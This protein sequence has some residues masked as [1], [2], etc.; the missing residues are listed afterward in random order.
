METESS[1]T[2]QLLRLAA[3]GDK[4]SWGKLLTL[5]VERLSRL[6]ALR[7]DRRIQGRVDAGDVIQEIYL[8]AW[9][10]LPDYVQHPSMPFYLWLRGLARNKLGELHR[11]HLGAQ[12]RD[13]RREDPQAPGEDKMPDT[14]STALNSLFL[15][16]ST[17]SKVA[18]RAEVKRQ[19]QEALES[20]DALDREVLA[21]RHFEQLTPAETAEVLGIKEKAAGMRY[22]RAIRRLKDV[23]TLLPGGLSEFRT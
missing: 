15:D 12:M 18:A 1:E 17:P 19:L 13:A 10:H 7:L 22:M 21:L 20:M 8:E 4:A 11:Q 23:L 3:Q 6:I 16:S 2:V 5:Y 14:T 9:R